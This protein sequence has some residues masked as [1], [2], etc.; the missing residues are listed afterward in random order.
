M[1]LNLYGILKTIAELKIGLVAGNFNGVEKIS[2]FEGFACVPSE[3][4][5]AMTMLALV[6]LKNLLHVTT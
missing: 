4:F 3:A 6:F 5:A 1:V 2:P